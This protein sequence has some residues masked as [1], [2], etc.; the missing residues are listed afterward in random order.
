MQ[1]SLYIHIP[2][3]KSRCHYCNFYTLPSNTG[4]P[5][6]YIDAQIRDFMRYAP[7]TAAGAPLRPATVY[8]GGGT[9]SMLTPQ[10]A[11]KIISAVNPRK[12]AEITLEANPESVT[13]KALCGFKA[14][15]VN[16]LSLGVQTAGEKNLETLGR[17][18]T[19]HMAKNA[20]VLANKAG[21]SNKSCDIML[22]LPGY[23]YDEL[24]DTLRLVYEGGAKHISA[25]MLKIE[26][27]TPFGKNRPSN[28]P[29]DDACADFYLYAVK[30]LAGYGYKQYEI[31]NFAQKGYKSRHNL[32]YW[33]VKNWLGI[34]P[35]AHSC[36]L[37]KRF[38]F[39]CDV[40]AFIKDTLPLANE[41]DM[42]A[43]DYIMLCMRLNKGLNERELYQKW[44]V[45]LSDEQAAFLQQLCHAGYAK[46]TK[47]SWALT[48]SGMLVQ[49]SILAKLFTV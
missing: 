39:G 3:C 21:F 4:V 13:Y 16:R 46:K 37:G 24:D 8:F 48:S 33:Q 41:P 32:A 18:H 12:N 36:I 7:K 42:T 31:S 40:N 35:S 10:Q 6:E 11:A 44:A 43:E 1:Y 45:A 20:L 5:D 47:H 27:E 26:G 19:P 25:Y 14:A 30:Q 28:L 49:N 17:L 22:A 34:G 29:S 38:S 15:G 2:F 23:S 9:P